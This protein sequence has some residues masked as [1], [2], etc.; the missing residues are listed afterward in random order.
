MEEGFANVADFLKDRFATVYPEEGKVPRFYVDAFETIP[1]D[2]NKDYSATD[3]DGN[4]LNDVTYSIDV[5]TVEEEIR[6]GLGIDDAYRVDLTIYGSYVI[7]LDDFIERFDALSA[8]LPEPLQAYTTEMSAMME[9]QYEKRYPLPFGADAY[10]SHPTKIVNN[11][12]DF[13]AH[14][15]LDP[16]LMTVSLRFYVDKDNRLIEMASAE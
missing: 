16:S 5:Q 9:E 15:G 10:E 1:Y 2:A 3:A 14:S 6:G 11:E 7:E 13:I 8:N 4:I 12:L